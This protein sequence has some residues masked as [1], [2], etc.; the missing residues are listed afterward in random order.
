[1]RSASMLLRAKSSSTMRMRVLFRGDSI[2]IAGHRFDHV[3]FLLQ[4]F[5]Q[6]RHKHVDRARRHVAGKVPDRVQKIASGK[7]PAFFLK[8]YGQKREFLGGEV[9]VLAVHDDAA[10]GQEELRLALLQD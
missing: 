6:A 5:S 9:H 3:A 2:A 1:M 10:G 8:E 4:F 7:G